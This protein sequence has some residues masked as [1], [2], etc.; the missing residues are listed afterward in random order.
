MLLEALALGLPI[1][2]TGFSSVSGVLPQGHGLVVPLTVNGVAAGM[3]AYLRGEVPA[4]KFDHDRYNYEAVQQFYRAIGA[5]MPPLP[6]AARP[7]PDGAGP[8]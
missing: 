3:L 6:S 4:P 1:V 7:V 5:V 2:T 8:G